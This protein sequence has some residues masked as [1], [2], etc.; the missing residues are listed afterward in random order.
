MAFYVLQHGWYIQINSKAALFN[1]LATGRPCG[2]IRCLN[3]NYLSG[4]ITLQVSVL[5]IKY[6]IAVPFG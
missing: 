1:M 6:Q 4:K 2:N 5:I 3:Q